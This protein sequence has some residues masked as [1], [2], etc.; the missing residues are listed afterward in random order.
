MLIYQ[1]A[2]VQLGHSVTENGLV[3]AVWVV[4]HHTFVDTKAVNL[5]P[6]QRGTQMLRRKS[7]ALAI[8]R[9]L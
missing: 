8:K 5:G 4:E 3:A 9:K 6:R 7:S 2:D 1:D